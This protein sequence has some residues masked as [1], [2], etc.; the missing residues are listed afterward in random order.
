MKKNDKIEFQSI[1]I[2][3]QGYYSKK[4][5]KNK[6]IHFFKKLT[7]KST[8]KKLERNKLIAQIMVIIFMP[9]KKF[10]LMAPFLN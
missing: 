5:L 9:N 8:M 4:C 1:P 10:A 7:S 6:I 3:I 2:H